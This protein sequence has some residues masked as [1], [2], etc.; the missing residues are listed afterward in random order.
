MGIQPSK[1]EA[2][3]FVIELQVVDYTSTVSTFDALASLSS[4]SNDAAPFD[5]IID[6]VGN[7][8]LYRQSPAYLKPAGRFLT[9]AGS[10][11]LSFKYPFLPVSL[12]GIPRSYT[13]VMGKTGGAA[14]QE[15]VDW[16]KKGLISNVPIDSIV[17]MDEAV[18]VTLS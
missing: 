10:P 8:Q 3:L 15:V 1:A 4:S 2:N 16:F 17:E 9:I 7:E 12:G 13:H 14:A 11:L 6:C 5:A 18:Q